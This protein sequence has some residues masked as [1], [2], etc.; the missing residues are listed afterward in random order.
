M[1]ITSLIQFSIASA[2]ETAVATV[3]RGVAAEKAAVYTGL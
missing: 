2:V 3:A 1:S